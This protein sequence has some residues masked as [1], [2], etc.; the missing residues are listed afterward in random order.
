VQLQLV[1]LVHQ[2]GQEVGVELL[3]LLHL[4]WVGLVVAAQ[5][6]LLRV[7]QQAA[8]EFFTFSIRR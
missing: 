3:D 5:V 8:M 6:S 1:L 2:Q 4:R 7:Q